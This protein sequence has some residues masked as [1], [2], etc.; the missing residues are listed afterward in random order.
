[1]GTTVPDHDQRSST[2]QRKLA[3]AAPPDAKIVEHLVERF[4][5]LGNSSFRLNK[6]QG[7]RPFYTLRVADTPCLEQDQG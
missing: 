2:S 7:W 5:T 1:M 4:R 3:A 6:Y